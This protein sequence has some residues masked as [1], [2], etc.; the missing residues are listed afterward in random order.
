[1]PQ[2]GERRIRW[3]RAAL[4]NLDQIGD[5]IA[6]DDPAAARRLVARIQQA[7]TLLAKHPEIGRPGRVPG[8]R[9]LVVPGTA[10]FIPYR[11]GA[12]AVEILRIIHGAQLWPPA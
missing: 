11:V 9:E 2:R 12:E 4:A 3:L 5:H 7:I 8:T 6:R 1:M 10:Y